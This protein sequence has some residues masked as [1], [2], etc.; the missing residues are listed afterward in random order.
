MP[1]A[2]GMDV[3]GPRGHNYVSVTETVMPEPDLPPSLQAEQ[4]GPV[5][6]L[7]LSR[8]EKRNALDPVTIDGIGRFFADPPAGARAIVLHGEGKHFCAGLDL[9]TVTETDATAGLFHSRHWHAAFERIEGGRLP[10]VAALHGAVVGGGL[11]LAMACHIRVAD[12]SAYYALPEGQRGIFVGGGAAVRLPRLVGVARMQDM[13]LTGRTYGAEDGER[14]GFSQYVVDEGQALARAIEVAARAA[15]TAPL[16]TFAVLH[17]LPRIAEAD[18]RIGGLME[19]LMAAI[20]VA[21]G[22][23][24]A[25]LRAFLNGQATKATH[26]PGT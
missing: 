10:V 11:E 7:R 4:H 12:R 16:T 20:A 19:S 2:R 3:P 23:A 13:M 21:D 5:A 24:K 14:A 9:G 15:E 22:D 8:P 25:R 6:V 26:R 17:A 1:C 18:P